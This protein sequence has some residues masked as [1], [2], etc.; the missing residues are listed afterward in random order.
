MVEVPVSG[1]GFDGKKDV[2]RVPEEFLYLVTDNSLVFREIA[3]SS[4][5]K[6]SLVP[7]RYEEP[8]GMEEK[9]RVALS[10]NEK[11]NCFM[12]HL[13]DRG[14]VKQ[15]LLRLGWP[16]K[17]EVPL[18]EGE[19]LEINLR[20]VTKAGRPFELRSYQKEAAA[21][22]VGDKGPGTGFGTIV[23]PCGAGKTVVGMTVMDLLKTSTLIIT[24]NISAVH[25]WIDELLDKTDLSADMIAEYTGE[26][27]VIKPVTVATTR[28]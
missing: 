19:P 2:K 10:E 13:T 3:A 20:K 18:S 25:Q 14:T 4:V 15:D 22:L 12:L 5:G 1:D 16:V 28:F 7:C 8:A 26:N 23:L 24:T 21:A 17:D 27:K 6:K 11:K 9:A